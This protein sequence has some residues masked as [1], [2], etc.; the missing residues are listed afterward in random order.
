M[1]CGRNRPF[2]GPFRE[3]IRPETEFAGLAEVDAGRP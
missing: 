2:S 1:D 3:L